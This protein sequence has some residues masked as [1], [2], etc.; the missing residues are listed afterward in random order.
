MSDYKIRRKR[1]P[2]RAE[3]MDSQVASRDLNVAFAKRLQKAMDAKGWS[4]SDLAREATKFLDQPADGEKRIE[5]TRDNV[6]KYMNGKTLPRGD[7]LSALARALGVEMADLVSTEGITSVA[8]RTPP[9]GA[10]D[11]GNGNAWLRVNQEVPWTT[12]LKILE[13]LKGDASE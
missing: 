7:R 1:A 3:M 12:A 13:L 10:S 6:S 11:T 9:V 2:L 4:Q 8:E 5:I